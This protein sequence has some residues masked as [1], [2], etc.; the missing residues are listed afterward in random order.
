MSHDDF[1]FPP[2]DGVTAAPMPDDL[3]KH[4]IIPSATWVHRNH[5]NISDF[6]ILPAV[7]F[8][9][10]A[11]KKS[12]WNFIQN[13]PKSS[14]IIQKSSKIIQKSSKNHPNSSKIIKNHQKIIQKSS[15]II[16]NHPKSSKIIQ[17]HPKI[18]P[19]SSKIIQK[20]SKNHPKSSKI[21]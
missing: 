8:S 16:Q 21:I 4:P 12:S 5:R 14:K 7:R 2:N 15:K 1:D 20:S 11:F 6:Q 3:T 18:I 9:Q 19:K 10:S 17:N 13:H